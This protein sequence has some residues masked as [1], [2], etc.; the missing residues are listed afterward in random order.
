M[1]TNQSTAA[2]MAVAHLFEMKFPDGNF[3]HPGIHVAQ[4]S[5][6]PG[7]RALVAK[8]RIERGSLLFAYEAAF[9]S[10]RT[11]TSIQVGP[12]HH[13]EAGEEGSYINH[14][15]SPNSV[16]RTRYNEVNIKGAVAF[17]ALSDIR[18]GEEIT[19]DYA[20]TETEL[21]EALAR[22]SCLCGA[23]NC[24]GNIGGYRFIDE[25]MKRELRKAD[26]LA[27]HLLLAN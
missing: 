17:W 22:T 18:P 26:L 21:T 13:L 14:S 2:E 9:S 25:G 12:S 7:E 24:R 8:A 19:F 5:L 23:W 11:R 10:T 16:V 1:L 3:C 6:I 20:T 27:N 4:S 15:C